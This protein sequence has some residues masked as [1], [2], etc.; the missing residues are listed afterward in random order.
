MH[1]TFFPFVHN[2]WWWLFLFLLWD[3]PLYMISQWWYGILP[4]WI[5]HMMILNED[6]CFCFWSLLLLRILS[7]VTFVLGLYS[8]YVILFYWHLL[9][10]MIWAH[11]SSYIYISVAL[12][13]NFNDHAVWCAFIRYYIYHFLYLKLSLCGMMHNY[14]WHLNVIFHTHHRL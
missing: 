5:M 3:L 8:S 13:L 2:V 6:F 1:Y 12:C 9:F 7:Y 14:I 4:R 10:M 11:V